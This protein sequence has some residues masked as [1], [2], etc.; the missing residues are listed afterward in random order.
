MSRTA[1]NWQLP[2]AIV[3]KARATEPPSSA[4]LD[5]PLVLTRDVCFDLVGRRLFVCGQEEPLSPLRF[6]VLR[7]LLERPGRVVSASDLVR[8]GILGRGSE[9]RYRGVMKEIRD[10]LGPGQDAIRT[11]RGVGYRFDPPR[12]TT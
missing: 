10:R 5:P 3:P 6:E 4:S 1:S 12:S 9:Q 2:A 8:A 7:H 11:V